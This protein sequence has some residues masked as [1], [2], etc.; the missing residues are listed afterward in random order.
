MDFWPIF[1]PLLVLLVIVVAIFNSLVSKRNRVRQAFA[2]V[3]VHLKKRHDLIP[4]LVSTVEGYVQHERNV[5]ERVTQ[6]RAQAISGNLS[7]RERLDAESQ[8]SKALGNLFAVC[9]NYPDLKAN[10]NFLHLQAALTEIE[11]QI[12]AARRFYNAAVTDYQNGV[13]MFPSNLIASL[14]GFRETEFYSIP[15]AE[16]QPVKASL[17]GP[18]AKSS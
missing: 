4:N 13:Q 10:K 7:S 14:F 8:I 17:S 1:L 11:E 18:T 16:R 6:L 2:G 5:L 9:E 15:E 3:D 12:S